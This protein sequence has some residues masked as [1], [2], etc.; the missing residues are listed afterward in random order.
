M[1]SSGDNTTP[2]GSVVV[3]QWPVTWDVNLATWVQIPVMKTPIYLFI[4][5]YLSWIFLKFSNCK[6][7]INSNSQVVLSQR[8]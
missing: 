4:I 8:C 6:Q 1:N 7:L 3:V 5:I 2:I